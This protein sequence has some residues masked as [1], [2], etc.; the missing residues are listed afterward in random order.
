MLTSKCSIKKRITATLIDLL[1]ILLASLL[2]EFF[3][4]LPIANNSFDYS[5]KQVDLTIEKVESQLFMFVDEKYEIIIDG[6]GDKGDIVANYQYGH[7]LINIKEYI[8]MNKNVGSEK[9]IEYLSKFYSQIKTDNFIKLKTESGYFSD[10][11]LNI[12]KEDI[13]EENRIIF[14]DNVFLQAD[15]DIIN[16]HD[17]IVNKLQADVYMIQ[18]S[19]E[20]ISFVIPMIIMLYII[21][22][23]NKYRSSVGKK[24]MKLGV[25]NKFYVPCNMLLL[26]T[27]FM[28]FLLIEVLLSLFVVALPLVIS[29]VLVL[30]FKNGQSLHDLLSTTMVID[31]SEFTPFEKI[32]DYADFIRKEKEAKERSLRRPYEN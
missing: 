28:S 26:T 24:I 6:D 7:K 20:I 11:D 19:V 18:L 15:K 2:L 27:R 29:F 3:V 31:I 9:Y 4:C 16:F 5:K 32:E 17:G 12:F 8:Y 30:L 1:I 13:S 23:T 22:L 10:I 21:P 25:V 14:C